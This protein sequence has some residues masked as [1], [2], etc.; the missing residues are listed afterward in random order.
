VPDSVIQ[1]SL[2]RCICEQLM[3]MPDERQFYV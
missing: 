2:K 3:V 1:F